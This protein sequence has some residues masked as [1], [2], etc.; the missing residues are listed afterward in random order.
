MNES[1]L[2]YVALTMTIFLVISLL[3]APIFLRPSPAARRILEL[4]QSSRPD[5]RKV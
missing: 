4:V 1:N 3:A 2:F 5:E